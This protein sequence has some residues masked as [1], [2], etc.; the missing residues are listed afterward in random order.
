M[1]N[2]VIVALI[3]GGAVLAVGLVGY[4]YYLRLLAKQ[5]RLP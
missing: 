5:D 1:N 3:I 2:E 4:V